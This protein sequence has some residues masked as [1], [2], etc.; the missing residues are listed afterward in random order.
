VTRHGRERSRAPAKK[1]YG[2]V[3]VGH[4]TSQRGHTPEELSTVLRIPAYVVP[5]DAAQ[6]SSDCLHAL[7]HRPF[8]AGYWHKRN[9]E[10][11]VERLRISNRR[12]S[13]VIL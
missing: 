13:R 8:G 4:A 7:A 5:N 10:R 6:L 2:L 9:S 11:E 12:G 1:H 3:H